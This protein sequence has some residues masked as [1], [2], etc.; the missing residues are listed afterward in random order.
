MSNNEAFPKNHDEFD[1]EFLGTIP[2]EPYTVQTNIYGNGGTHIGREQRFRLWFDP[3]ESF[4]NYSF[5]WTANHTV[6]FVDN[7]PIWEFPR[8]ASMGAQYPS[9]Q[10]S[11]YAT[12]W[13]ASRWATDGG[14]YKVNYDYQPFIATYSNII[15]SG[16][17]NFNPS[18][19][20]VDSCPGIY[21]EPIPPGLTRQQLHALHWVQQNHRFY[22][23][24]T[25]LKRYPDIADIPECA[26][27]RAQNMHVGHGHSQMRSTEP[28][29]TTVP[30]RPGKVTKIE[31][32]PL[33]G[34]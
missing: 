34:H 30:F 10:M 25:D 6:F 15:L 28:T 22:S 5:L 26:A 16:C 8:L 11:L 20:P 31:P 1:F 3:T 24:C 2:G 13:D 29:P 18:T 27:E 21:N 9:K 12:I 4:H 14:L 17:P 7:I 19:P 33:E 23:Y 32:A